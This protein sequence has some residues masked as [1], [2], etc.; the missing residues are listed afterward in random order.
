[1]P[2]TILVLILA[3]SLDSQISTAPEVP[4]VLATADREMT[5]VTDAARNPNLRPASFPAS[6]PHRAM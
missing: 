5:T 2:T 1:M 4:K 3:A 6:S